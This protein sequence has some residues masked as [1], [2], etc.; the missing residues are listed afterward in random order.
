M[1]RIDHWHN[2]QKYQGSSNMVT[3]V[4]E[5][6]AEEEY[7]PFPQAHFMWNKIDDSENKEEACKNEMTPEE[8]K[9]ICLL[10]LVLSSTQ[11]KLEETQKKLRSGKQIGPT[12]HSS[13]AKQ[14]MQSSALS[15][16]KQ[17]P[18][19]PGKTTPTKAGKLT[20]AEAAMAGQP[21]H[22]GALMQPGNIHSMPLIPLR[23]VYACKSARFSILAVLHYV[24]KGS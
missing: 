1:E 16:S 24:D 15:N 21:N 4:E 18:P 14:N 13:A 11:K 23:S 5:E 9:E 19:K 8:D 20:M 12:T 10:Q 3:V 17:I 7:A 6:T 2:A 22:A